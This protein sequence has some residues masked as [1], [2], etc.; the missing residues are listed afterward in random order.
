M[1][2]INLLDP[3][4]ANLIAA[5]EVV[6]RPASV[7]KELLENSIDSK[8]TKIVA[9]IRNGGN[10]LIRITDNGCGMSYE[11]AALCVKR[12]AT[13]KIKDPNDLFNINTLGFRGEALAAISSVCRFTVMTKR[14]EDQTGTKFS[15][16]GDE[17]LYYDEFGCPDGTTISVE[18]LFLNQ[19]ARQKFL[20]KD[21]T[22]A[23]AV[24][25][26][27]QRIAISHP[28]I[29]FTFISNNET[30]LQTVGDSK[31]ESA[32]YCV[33]GKEFSSSL[34]KL[35]YKSENG[36]ALSGFVTRPEA[37]RVNR[38]FQ[39][40]YINN[41]FVKSKTM[42]FALED[43]YKSYMKSDRFPG[44]VINLTLDPSKVDVNVH[45]AKLEVRFS[46]ERSVYNA[47][48]FGVRR[49]LSNQMSPLV[50]KNTPEN[51]AVERFVQKQELKQTSLDFTK[52]AP[53]I[54]PYNP[55]S[56]IVTLRQPHVAPSTNVK[57][58]PPQPSLSFG[59]TLIT[60]EEN[61]KISFSFAPK[62]I[63][64]ISEKIEKA[65]ISDESPVPEFIKDLPQDTAEGEYI[66]SDGKIVGVC[67]DAYII[68]QT[69]EDIFFI[70]KHAAHERILY[71]KL[72][73]EIGNEAIQ[74]LIEPINLFLNSMQASAV[75]QH[76]SEFESVG[77][78]VEPF[79]ENEYVL[80]GIPLSLVGIN[81]KAMSEIFEATCDDLLS[82][83]RI[84]TKKDSVI[85]RMLYSIACKA[86]VKAGIPDTMQD[87]QFIVKELIKI[88]NIT[89]CPHGRPVVT[90]MSQKQLERLF[91]R[92]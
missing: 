91:L 71:E 55:S 62:P 70:D 8:A 92:S 43:A 52:A 19:P 85:D 73:K 39:S 45:P 16:L 35:D 11:D 84:N 90:K 50:D 12:H 58:T 3:Q 13:S 47:V 89:V 69:K 5:G 67:F 74:M 25:Q 40:F 81:S 44:C 46:D 77:F 10:T 36:I 20:K 61:N 60:A 82:G 30:K 72:K 76:L 49:A 1:S 32:I 56:D 78:I 42:L 4:T 41:R 57:Q 17:I 14:A 51:D 24:L 54:A 83:G 79:G 27:V 53:K 28:E 37:S 2:V 18:D 26:T 7:V 75:E 23:A 63:S 59:Q 87:Y 80:R 64:P 33:Y 9:E 65:H 38:S 29:S 86:A 66:D 48:Y 6:D 88:K 34:T 21:S 15:I 68:Y 31:L 22:E